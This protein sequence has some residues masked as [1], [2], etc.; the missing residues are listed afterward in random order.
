V[1]ERNISSIDDTQESYRQTVD[2]FIENAL[3]SEMDERTGFG[4]YDQTM[5]DTETVETVVARKS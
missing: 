1:Q 3:E 5:Q 2:Q 4:R